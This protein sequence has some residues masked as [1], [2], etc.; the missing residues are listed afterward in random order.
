MDSEEWQWVIVSL[1]TTVN[2]IAAA[3]PDAASL[4]EQISTFHGIKCSATDLANILFSI[5]V[6]KYISPGADF[7]SA[8]KPGIAPWLSYLKSISLFFSPVS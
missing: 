7:F 4:L 3:A 2:P 5:P 6:H 1:T 8:G